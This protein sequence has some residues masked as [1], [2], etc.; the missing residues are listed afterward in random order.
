[1]HH[2]FPRNSH[3]IVITPT[4]RGASAPNVAGDMSAGENPMS[5]RNPMYQQYDTHRG[6]LGHSQGNCRP[7]LPRLSCPGSLCEPSAQKASDRM[8]QRTRKLAHLPAIAPIIL[9]VEAL[10]HS[11]DEVIGGIGPTAVTE[12]RFVPGSLW[13]E[14]SASS[15]QDDGKMRALPV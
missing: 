14:R 5:S 11:D 10:G 7:S 15:T 13:V 6:H 12:A 9:I 2:Q 1:M 4:L 8:N 3:S